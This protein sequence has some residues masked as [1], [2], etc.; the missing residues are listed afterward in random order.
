[1]PNMNAPIKLGANFWNQYVEWP[2]FLEGML[3]AEDLGYDSLFTWDHV[4][5]IIGSWDGPAFETYTAMAAVAAQTK[6]AT[7]GH[8][9]TAVFIVVAVNAQQLPVAAIRRIVVMVVVFMVNG[10]LPQTL[11]QNVVMINSVRENFRTRQKPYFSTGLICI[12]NYFKWFNRDTHVVN[13]LPG[14]SV[15]LNG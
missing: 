3:E 2:R 14:M 9:V 7:I 13:L 5:P 1:M 11:G 10:Q 6:R 15:S 8:L 4:Y 12:P